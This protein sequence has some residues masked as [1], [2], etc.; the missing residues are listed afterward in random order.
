MKNVLIIATKDC[1]QR[2][3]LK[4]HLKEIGV[5]CTV[6]CVDDDPELIKK[7]GITNA[8]NIIIDGEVVFRG[9]SDQHLPSLAELREMCRK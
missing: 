9:Q 7:Y 8:P 5:R 2:H 1:Q 4:E 3:I 6:K